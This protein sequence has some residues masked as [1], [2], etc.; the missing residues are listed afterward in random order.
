MKT[1]IV[2]VDLTDKVETKPFWMIGAR[3]GT[4]P[5]GLL[6]LEREIAASLF[7]DVEEISSVLI[8]NNET[9]CVNIAVAMMR[10]FPKIQ[11]FVCPSNSDFPTYSPIAHIKLETKVIGDK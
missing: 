6:E 11:L 5:S 2:E 4:D 9:D 1:N 7:I 8:Y 10:Q 3:R